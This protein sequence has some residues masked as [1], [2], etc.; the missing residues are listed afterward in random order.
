MSGELTA[1]F[2]IVDPS[3]QKMIAKYEEKL[4]K[5]KEKAAGEKC[6]DLFDL[7]RR[8]VVEAE[9]DLV[10]ARHIAENID[11]YASDYTNCSYREVWAWLHYTERHGISEHWSINNKPDNITEEWR[12]AIDD[13]LNF[14]MPSAND[15]IGFWTDTE[16]VAVQGYE[17][18]FNWLKATVK[19]YA[20]PPNPERDRA[21]RELT[22]EIIA[23]LK[24][25]E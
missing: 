7:H 18:T 19:A 20:P 8:Y 5:M 6:A 10:E 24:S 14:I 21:M 22:A 17:T 9:R 25:Q 23:R 12:K 1:I 3:P 4:T 15:L 2:P 13:W 11:V 16:F